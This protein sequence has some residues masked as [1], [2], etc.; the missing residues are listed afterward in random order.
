L[1]T[2]HPQSDI[3]APARRPA[4]IGPEGGFQ[5]CEAGRLPGSWEAGVALRCVWRRCGPGRPAGGAAPGRRCHHPPPAATRGEELGV[6]MQPSV[7]AV[8]PRILLI[9]NDAAERARLR[10]ALAPEFALE[11]ATLGRA[12]VEAASQGHPDLVLVDGSLPDLE[13]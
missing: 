8:S 11:E 13:G 3:Q 2:V 1:S 6:A 4:W 9:E 10:E 12:G 5:A 7:S